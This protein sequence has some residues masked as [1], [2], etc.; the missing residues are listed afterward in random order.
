M[1]IACVSCCFY[2]V[3][4]DVAVAVAIVVDI[5]VNEI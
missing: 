3:A 5:V 2:T 4:V 1:C